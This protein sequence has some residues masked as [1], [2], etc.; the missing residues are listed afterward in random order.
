MAR[1][2]T[3]ESK[4]F[5]QL[6]I[7]IV[8]MLTLIIGFHFIPPIGTITP[9]GM[10]LIG[11]FLAILYG[12][13]TCGMLWPS[14]L[15]IVVLPFSNAVTIKEFL[16][17]SFGNET[18]VFILFIFIFTGVIDEVGLIDY[19]ANKMISFK[20]LNGR[21]WLFSAFLLIGA[22]I[23]SAFINM[24]ASIIV[25]W[26]IIYIVAERFAFKPY[27][28]YPT[29]MILGVALA[30]LIGG[31]VMP[32]KPVPLVVLKAY[33]TMAGVP[34][35][36][37]QYICFSLPVTL[38]IMIFYVLICRWVFRPDIKI[39]HQIS[40]DFANKKA[41][42]LNKKQKIAIVFLVTFILMMIA[43][44]ILPK[45]WLLANIINQLGI[46]GC[47]F[48]LLIIMHW[49]KI[50]GVVLLNFH[51][52][53]KHISWDMFM[54]MCFVIPFASIFT[55]DATG[56]KESIIQVMHP[57]LAGHSPMIFIILTLFIATILTNV[58]NNMVVGA[59]FATLIFTI[60]G[61]M[62]INIEPIIAV[63]IVCCNLALAT[64]AAAPTTAMAFANTK[65]CRPTD[66][67]KYGIFTVLLGFMFA[68][69]LG[70][71]WATIIY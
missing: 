15:G 45:Q 40:A 5:D 42:M 68:S 43:P 2:I 48:L 19:I 56:I 46:V 62:N 25:F 38:A 8:I 9:I 26:G 13:T 49:V 17:Q 41:L 59:V 35:D 39:L 70:L 23:S 52:M 20:V 69:C 64:P 51:T 28:K 3:E 7:H 67:Y 50:D 22:Y 34:M 37:F 11:I 18:I 53:A 31:C 55:G 71:L 33:S 30:S 27:D 36:F 6:Y 21:P 4:K 66:L 24:F 60:G 54:V 44:S 16:M 63:L 29:L 12:W 57:L 61:T 65:W 1:Q 47:L 10:K 14:M 32:Y 58:A